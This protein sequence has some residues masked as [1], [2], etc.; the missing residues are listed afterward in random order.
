VKLTHER[1]ALDATMVA[2]DRRSMNDGVVKK[3]A[4][5][6]RP[7]LGWRAYELMKHVVW[8]TSMGAMTRPLALARTNATRGVL[9]SRRL[10]RGRLSTRSPL[11]AASCAMAGGGV[12]LIS[13]PGPGVPLSRMGTR[14]DR[15][16][17]HQGDDVHLE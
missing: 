17:G 2:I 13:P 6:T 10:L 7:R 4:D 15:G 3:L 9:C 1:N 16:G 14:S 11:P 8:H 5:L 12:I